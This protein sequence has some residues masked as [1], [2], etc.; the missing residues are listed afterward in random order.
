VVEVI[1]N[2]AKEKHS[3][4]IHPTPIDIANVSMS[5]QGESF[6]YHGEEYS[7]K[8]LGN[9]QVS[10]AITVIEVCKLLNTMGYNIPIECL[11]ESLES[12]QV[13]FRTQTLMQDGVTIIA[14]GSHNI[15]G[16]TALKDTLKSCGI[17]N[18]IVLTGMIATKDYVSCCK[19]LDSIS[20]NVVCTDGYI[21]NAIDRLEL[22]QLFSGT[23]Y[24]PELTSALATAKALA[25]DKCVPLVVC[26]SL[27]LLSEIFKI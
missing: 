5:L 26:G 17:D 11:K 2:I 16:V 4:F 13:T 15:G 10:N 18:P 24:T 27:Y 14:D 23:V 3:S 22:S 25:K 21:Y 8:M 7:I 9:H 19:V 12:T 20:N 1:S 6:Q